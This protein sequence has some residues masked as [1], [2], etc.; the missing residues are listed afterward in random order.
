MKSKSAGII[1]TGIL[2]FVAAFIWIIISIMQTTLLEGSDKYIGLW[3]FLMAI[4]SIVIGVGLVQHKFWSRSWGLWTS[5]INIISIGYSWYLSSSIFFLFFII[6]YLVSLILI[7]A[8]YGAFEIED[9]IE[10]VQSEPSRLDFHDNNEELS[11]LKDSLEKGILTQAEYDRKVFDIEVKKHAQPLLDHIVEM[12][13]KGL[14]S[15]NEYLLKEKEIIDKHRVELENY[16]KNKPKLSDISNDIIEKLSA[17]NKAR[18]ERFIEVITPT[19]LIVLHENKIK[20]IGIER[21]NAIIASNMQDKFEI[22]LKIS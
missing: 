14:L 12:R 13:N 19:D 17:Q 3:N 2:F 6:V 8:N 18:L 16:I 4:A 1:V 21:W 7:I 15:D 20:L 9:N 5:I 10:I 11:L 22:I